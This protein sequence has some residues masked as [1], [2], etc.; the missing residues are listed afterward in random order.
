[1][2]NRRW[3]SALLGGSLTLF[4]NP[5][6][7]LLGILAVIPQARQILSQ[8]GIGAVS[9]WALA[10]QAVVFSLVS[11]SWTRRTQL[12]EEY[13]DPRMSPLHFWEVWYQ[14]VGWATV[15]NAVFAAAQ[16]LLFI[17]ARGHGHRSRDSGTGD[18]Y[19]PLLY[20]L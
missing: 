19:A 15:D 20:D 16:G 8:P 4:I 18:E 11:A 17:I 10:L 13:Y 1:M 2:T 5:L 3:F 7:T 12:P 9:I 6:A 14:L